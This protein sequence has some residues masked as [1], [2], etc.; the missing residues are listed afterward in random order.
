MIGILGG[1][2]GIKNDA[3]KG[4]FLGVKNDTDSGS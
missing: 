1:Q 2:K 3:Q 4:T